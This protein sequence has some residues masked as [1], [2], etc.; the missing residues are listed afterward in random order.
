MIAMKKGTKMVVGE[1]VDSSSKMKDP[2][3]MVAEKVDSSSKKKESKMGVA[4][5]LMGDAMKENNGM[6]DI[7]LGDGT[8]QNQVRKIME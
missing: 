7:A 4:E 2:K 8:S 1:K 3:T 5:K 6:K